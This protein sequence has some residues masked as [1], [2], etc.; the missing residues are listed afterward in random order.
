MKPFYD[1]FA[2]IHILT[3]LIGHILLKNIGK[4][5]GDVARIIYLCVTNHQNGF[6]IQD[7]TRLQRLF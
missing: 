7:N 2:N 6:H 3:Q 5:L 4:L 1:H